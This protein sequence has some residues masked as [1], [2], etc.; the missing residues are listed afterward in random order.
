M[1][2]WFV[3]SWSLS[4]ASMY[5]RSRHNGMISQHRPTI[6]AILL[7]ALTTI[8]AS[9]AEAD[10]VTVFAE[11]IRPMVST[12]CAACH[13]DM[14]TKGDLNLARFETLPMVI[15]SVAIW[16]RAAKRI[17]SHE[18][19][20]KDSPQPSEAERTQLVEW[21]NKL[22]ANVNDCNQIASE[23]SQSWYPG[24]VMSRRLN[25]F[26]YENTIRDVF[27]IELNLAETFPADGAGGEGFDNNGN[28]LFLSAIQMEKYVATAD[29]VV[30][31]LFPHNRYDALT[32]FA[33]G[34][35][36]AVTLDWNRTITDAQAAAARDRVLTVKPDRKTRPRQAAEQVLL[37]FAER[38]WRRPVSPGEVDG[39]LALYDQ[40]R[41]RGDSYESGIKLALK[42][43]LVSPNFLFLAEPEPETPGVYALGGYPLAARLSYFLWG[44]MPDDTLFEAARDGS[45]LQPDTLKQQV[46]RMLDDPKARALGD[47][48][49]AQWLGISQLGDIAKP[50]ATRYPEFDLA[51]A[52]AERD[53]AAL[54]F[55][56]VVSENLSLT[57]LIDADYTF[58][59]E[60]LAGIYGIEGVEGPE[61]RRVQLADARRGGV[62]GMAGVLTAT[63]HPLRTSPVL[64]GKWVLEQLLGERVPPPPPN[65][66]QLP[67]DEQ[68]LEGMT[69]RQRLEAHRKNPEC[70]SCHQT[71]DPIGFGL[72]NFDPIGRWREEQSGQPIDAAGTLPN[73]AA[74]NGPQELKNILLS[75]K[76]DFVRNLARKMLGYALGRSLTRFDECVVND[77]L[78]ALQADNYH[79]E[80]LFQS[81]VLSHPFRHRYAAHSAEAGE[82]K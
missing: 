49:A 66:P 59:N 82:Q 60:A 27:G 61:M 17:Q 30:E 21:I 64:R 36:K 16:Q 74:F 71:M 40:A 57:E 80:H 4:S 43:A 13:N 18:M 81:I 34:I 50:D 68:H 54:L 48:F 11:Q 19:P 62:L 31:T 73:G 9:T 10:D 2:L 26:E 15:E 41:E 44:S 46:A 63:S 69:L 32:S 42:A 35:G 52:Q 24:Y 65:V 25:R 75:R 53:E 23:E 6:Y 7:L 14:K 77:T 38:A 78:A 37:N 1:L 79:A 29:L 70:A 22:D 51:L 56:A 58:A 67:E 39:L 72:E 5:A 76:D 12:Y 47:L 33:R 3:L 28:A 45:L 20:P 8:I 55:H